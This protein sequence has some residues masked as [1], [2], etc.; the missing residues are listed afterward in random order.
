MGEALGINIERIR[1][2]EQK[3]LNTLPHVDIFVAMSNELSPAIRAIGRVKNIYHCQFPFPMSSWHVSNC[4]ENVEGY[5]KVIVNS[6]FTR[7][8]YLKQASKYSVKIPD[9]EILH[10]PVDV[11]KNN[12]Q[13]DWSGSDIKI[14]NVGRYIS[15]GHCK[16][17]LELIEEF[18]S[19]HSL[20]KTKGIN[21]RLSFVG[22]LAS[23]DED[24][25]YFSKLK[26]ASGGMPVDFYVNAPLDQLKSLYKESH[27][28]WHGTGIN[29]S[30]EENPEV[31]E[32]FG[33]APIEAMSFGA[34]PVV[35]KSGGPAEILKDFPDN[36]ASEITDYSTIT[37][38]LIESGVSLSGDFRD[39][40]K[41][42]DKLYFS[43]S[44][45]GKII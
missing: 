43:E 12:V 42:F 3:K 28:Y 44:L 18:K 19:L 35:W 33:I 27:F 17:Q 25:N 5:D 6:D 15:G 38:N 1:L 10:P 41:K 29:E 22:A 30:V 4:L 36:I 8:N 23:S 45:I 37:M 32:H 2:I 11:Y 34:I 31:F 20:G 24:R 13:K 26:E 7:K 9:V 39:L 14:L 16:K 40:S 21:F